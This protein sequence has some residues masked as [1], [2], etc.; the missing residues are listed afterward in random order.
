[1]LGSAQASVEFSSIPGTYKDLV[2]EACGTTSSDGMILLMR[3]N[4]DTG[5]NYSMTALSGNGTTARSDR[6]SNR[7]WMYLNYS[8]GWSS[9]QISTSIVQFMSYANTNVNKTVLARGGNA[10]GSTNPGTDA[11]VGLWRSTSAITSVNVYPNASAN[12]NTGSTFRLWGVS[13]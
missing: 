3:L 10:N 5:T 7:G 13:G 9:S 4:G 2:L 8:V 11:I 12:F 1:M 6:D